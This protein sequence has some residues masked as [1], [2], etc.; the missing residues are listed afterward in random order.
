[1]LC[2]GAKSRMLISRRIIHLQNLATVDAF[3]KLPDLQ[4]LIE[5]IICVKS[6][7]V[8]TLDRV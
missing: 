8:G 2:A 7:A 3:E 4:R 6:L 1:M 5:I